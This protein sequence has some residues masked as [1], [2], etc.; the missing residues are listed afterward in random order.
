MGDQSTVSFMPTVVSPQRSGQFRDSDLVGSELRP[1][2]T[3]NGALTTT[4]KWLR[5]SVS[6][7]WFK[8]DCCNKN[9]TIRRATVALVSTGPAHQVKN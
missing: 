2:G 3:Q 9:R 7:S 6:L 4:R 5:V 8:L 1:Q